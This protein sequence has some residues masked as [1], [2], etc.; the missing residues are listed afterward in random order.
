MR[1]CMDIYTSEKNKLNN[2]A[3]NISLVELNSNFVKN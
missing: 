1:R 2:N 3:K